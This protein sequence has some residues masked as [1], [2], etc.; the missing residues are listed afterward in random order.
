MPATIPT[1]PQPSEQRALLTRVDHVG[2][3]CRNLDE[4]VER[5]RGTFGL[6][7]VSAEVN[8]AQGVREA[9][10]GAGPGYVQLLEPLGP[11]TPV[12]KFLARR[13]E[14]IHHVGY[15]V[16]DIEAALAAI[17]AT[18]IRLIDERPRHGSMGASIAFLHPGDLG[19][20]L[21]EL[22]QARGEWDLPGCIGC[23]TLKPT[24]QRVSSSSVRV[25]G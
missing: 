15:G 17:G 6:D 5:Y 12:G 3:A 14:G 23:R 13:G 11:D 7:V 24:P 2:I 25:T 4:A 21:T 16:D 19:G 10:L 20:V 9:M 18:G 22:V 1:S 8:E